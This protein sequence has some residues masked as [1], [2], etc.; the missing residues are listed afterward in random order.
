MKAGLVQLCWSHSYDHVMCSI[1]NKHAPPVSYQTLVAV[2]HFQKLVTMCYRNNHYRF[3]CVSTISVSHVESWLKFLYNFVGISTR[4]KTEDVSAYNRSHLDIIPVN[5]SLWLL[6]MESSSYHTHSS[7]FG[8]LLFPMI[9][10]CF[11]DN[12]RDSIS[13]YNGWWSHTIFKSVICYWSI[14]HQSH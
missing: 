6:E 5:F 2:K 12:L 1:A 3:C 4:L 8:V 14:R 13:N 10:T 11:V 9:L 7:W